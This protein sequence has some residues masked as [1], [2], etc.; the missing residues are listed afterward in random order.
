MVE[1]CRSESFAPF[2]SC[3]LDRELGR[4]GLRR[5]ELGGMDSNALLPKVELVIHTHPRND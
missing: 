4:D 3:V 5:C 1:R 2:V